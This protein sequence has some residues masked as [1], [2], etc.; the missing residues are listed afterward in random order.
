MRIRSRNLGDLFRVA[1]A[2]L[3]AAHGAPKGRSI[4]GFYSLWG[5]DFDGAAATRNW[6][7]AA[8]AEGAAE[9]FGEAKS[10]LLRD[11]AHDRLVVDLNGVALGERLDFHNLLGARSGFHGRHSG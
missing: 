9:A 5:A 1:I 4:Y 7:S 6:R 3:N 10:F 2:S 11:C 8:S